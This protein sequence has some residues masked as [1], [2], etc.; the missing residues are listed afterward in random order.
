MAFLIKVTEFFRDKEAF[1]YIREHVLP[2]LIEQGRENGRVLRLWSAGCATGEEPYSLAMMV[3]DILG[4]E[5]PEWSIRI[6]ATDLDEDA[7]S[8]AR[9]GLYPRSTLKNLREDYQMRY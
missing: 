5:L 1:N 2:A 9:R 4:P 7:I 3:A 8:F 6:F